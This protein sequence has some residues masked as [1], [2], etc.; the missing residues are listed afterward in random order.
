MKEIEILEQQEMVYVV[1]HI[2]IEGVFKLGVT[3][4]FKNRLSCMNSA[5][6]YGMEVVHVEY[7]KWPRLIEDSV[8]EKWKDNRVNGE[9]ITLN[10][11]EL[12]LLKSDLITTVQ[13][14][15]D[16]PG[17]YISSKEAL[18]IAGYSTGV[19]PKYSYEKNAE[20]EIKWKRPKYQKSYSVN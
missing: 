4:N 18:S 1:K 2:G 16:C 11:S 12:E 20:F 9:W 6:P 7:T 15:S 5:S 3:S 8:L 19:H 17:D 13:V 10:E 14:V